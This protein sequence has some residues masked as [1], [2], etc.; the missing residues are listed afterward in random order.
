MTVADDFA[1]DKPDIK[2]VL[3]MACVLDKDVLQVL[4]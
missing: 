2:S 3:I 1:F 4:T